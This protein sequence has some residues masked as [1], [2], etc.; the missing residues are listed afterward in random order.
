MAEA[1]MD[2]RTIQFVMGHADMKM[3][4]KTYDHVSIERAQQQM[5]KLD[6]QQAV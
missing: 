3:I 6:R 4:Q 5:K 1:E 2:P